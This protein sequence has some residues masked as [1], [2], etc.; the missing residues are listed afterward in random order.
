MKHLSALILVTSLFS[1]SLS[2]ELEGD[3]PWGLEAVT[4]ARTGYAYRGF[5]LAGPLFDFQLEGELVL[6]EDLS[7]N[8]GG[9]LATEISDDF[10]EGAAFID[11]RYDLGERFAAGASTTYRGFDHSFF[12][13]G[14][15]VGAF[16]TWFVGE[17]W[18]ITTGAYRDFG[19][20]A[21]YANIESGWSY[22]LSDDAYFG[23]SGGVSAVDS[24]YGRSG[25][26]DFYGRA[27]VTYNI[28]STISLTPFLGWSFEIEKADGDEIL[29]GLWFEISF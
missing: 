13:D 14:F 17:E 12:K 25:L 7:L 23:L 21:W 29:G 22:R 28:N 4:G 16:L 11:I 2:A 6:R 8:A 15:D 20:D 5:D 1:P 24:Y 3:I 27:S 10:T 26:N 19:A 9:W 18:D